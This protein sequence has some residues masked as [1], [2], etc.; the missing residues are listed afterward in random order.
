LRIAI[1]GIV[2]ETNTYCRDQTPL[3]DFYIARGEK[4]LRS[5]GTATN[6]GGALDTCARLGVDVV[7]IM[8]AAAQPSGTIVRVAYEEM[9]NEILD[10]I[11]REASIDGIYLDLHG[12]GVVDGV[13]DLEGDL[14]SAIRDLVGDRLPMTASFDLHGNITQRMADGLNG[15]F[16][17]HQYPHVDMHL[18]AAEAIELIVEMSRD[19][20][21]PVLHVETIPMLIPTSTTFLGPGK[22]MLARVLAEEAGDETIDVSWFHGFPYTDIEHVG[23]H[24][25][26]TGRGDRER[27]ASLARKVARDLWQRRE[28]FAPTSLSASEALEQARAATDR[29]VVINETSDNCGGGAPG[30]GTH[31]LRAMLDAKLENACFGFIVDPEVAELAHQAGVGE[32][33][34]VSLGGK[35]DDLHGDPLELTVY[36]KALH[37]GRL[38]MQAMARGARINYGKLARL[39]VQDMDIIVASNR[40]QTFDAEP[41]LALGIDVTRLDFI[42]LKSSNHFRAGFSEIAGTIITADTPGLMTHRIEVFPR[43]NA[44]QPMWPIDARAN[45]SPDGV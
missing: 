35:Y 20:F 44:A 10:G 9:K 8:V 1:A 40:S 5:A 45:Y 32:T 13:P 6:L 28:E 37:D 31:L 25:C 3:S 22:E 15:V 33:I 42:A 27:A 34:S 36:V 43:E 17:C 38:T 18:R 19:E 14:V 30:D 12:A 29:P 11:S 26:V 16:A 24:I 7:P 21:R 4:I 23:T 39:V 41:F 2:H